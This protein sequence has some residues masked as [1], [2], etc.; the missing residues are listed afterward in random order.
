M[1]GQEEK[2]LMFFLGEEYYGVPIIKVNEII[3]VMEITR[4]PRT[5][6]FMK[7]IINL[8]GK[9]IPVMDLRLK[10]NM[11]ERKYDEET[12]IIIIE[13]PNNGRKNFM[14]VI[15]DKVAE[16]VNIYSGDVDVPPQ[17]GQEEGNE[18][19]TGVGKVKDK[20]VLLLEI[21]AIINFHEIVHLIPDNVAE[22]EAEAKTEVIVETLTEVEPEAIIEIDNEMFN[23]ETLEEVK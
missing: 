21:E 12:C 8:R 17:Y 9:I 7:G 23:L 13:I 19:I 11:T 3:G 14:G 15:V 10:F 16:V 4:V 5:P 20:V 22:V 2:Y 1:E 6:S 18:F